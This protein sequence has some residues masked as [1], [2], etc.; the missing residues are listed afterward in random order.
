MDGSPDYPDE[1]LAELD[2]VI[3][4]VHTSFNISERAMTERVIAA[5]E[6]PLVDCIGH[7]TG[8]LL[9]RGSLTRSTSSGSPRPRSGRAR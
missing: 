8:R 6:H 5:M 9:L 3:C 4:S 7:L 2:W 1:L